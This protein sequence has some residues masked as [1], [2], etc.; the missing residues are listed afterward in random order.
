MNKITHIPVPIDFLNRITSLEIG[1]RFGN[2]GE[3]L[4]FKLMCHIW[5][6]GG[7]YCVC[8]ETFNLY[9]SRTVMGGSVPSSFVDEVITHLLKVGFFDETQKTNNGI[10]TSKELQD[11]WLNMMS[12]LRRRTKIDVSYDVLT[13]RLE[14]KV[15][16]KK[17]EKKEDYIDFNYDNPFDQLENDVALKVVNEWND[18]FKDSPNADIMII[19]N[20]Q[21]DM[22]E[23]FR[24]NVRMCEQSG[25][26]IKEIRTS[27]ESIRDGGDDFPWT[28]QTAIRPN[29]V[30]SNILKYRLKSNTKTKTSKLGKDSFSRPENY[31]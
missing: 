1:E 25:L 4:I 22:N 28:L 21:M 9:I 10:L 19:K 23:M 27:F 16:R 6:N 15:E 17:E 18:V 14:K 3:L 13:Q 8:D 7:Y 12:K 11:S 5:T 29:N 26:T 2:D 24:H 31:T 30:R 20:P